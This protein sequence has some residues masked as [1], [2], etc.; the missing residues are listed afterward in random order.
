VVTIILLECTAS[1]LRV[2]VNQVGI[3]VGKCMLLSSMKCYACVAYG[4]S[5]RGPLERVIGK[6]TF[7]YMDYEGWLISLWLSKENSKLRD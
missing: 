2:E 1:L 6:T 5:T 4:L 3:E 7:Y